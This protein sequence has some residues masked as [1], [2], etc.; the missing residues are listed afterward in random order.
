MSAPCGAPTA[1]PRRVPITARTAPSLHCRE[2]GRGPWIGNSEE[3]AKGD[4]LPAIEK[5]TAAVESHT[6]EI[7]K[8]TEVLTHFIEDAKVGLEKDPLADAEDG[9]VL[10]QE[11]GDTEKNWHAVCDME[12]SGFKV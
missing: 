7:N 5:G 10:F 3:R 12:P 2:I 9:S 11:L 6:R 1:A 8:Q 4:D